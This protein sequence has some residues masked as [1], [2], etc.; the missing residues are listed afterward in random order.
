MTSTIEEIQKLLLEGKTPKEIEA[1]GYAH[2]TV[3][4]AKK[5]LE[6][7]RKRES[8]LDVA[9]QLIH[10]HKG[11]LEIIISDLIMQA[12]RTNDQLLKILKICEAINLLDDDLKKSI[13]TRKELEEIEKIQVIA[14]ALYNAYVIEIPSEEYARG[15]VRLMLPIPYE[16]VEEYLSFLKDDPEAYSF[17]TEHFQIFEKEDEVFDS[18]K[19]KYGKFAV[20]KKIFYHNITVAAFIALKTY[21]ISYALPIML[22]ILRKIS[23]LIQPSTLSNVLTVYGGARNGGSVDKGKR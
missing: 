22:G 10:R 1:M 18:I 13:L 21:F 12:I 9:R 6:R 16:K 20:L 15:K 7:K 2:S 23:D 19:E 11:T 14:T 3:I 4:E 8:L 5:R 17:I